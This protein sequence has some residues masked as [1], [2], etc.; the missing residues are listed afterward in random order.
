MNDKTQI[1]AVIFGCSGL[2]LTPQERAF[3]KEN[4]P[5]GL[6][7]FDRNIKDPEQLKALI[8]D[9]KKTVGREDAPILVD[10]EGGRV[11]RLWPPY[12]NGLGWNRT[13]G[14][15][16]AITPQKGIDGVKKHAEI[17]AHDLLSVGINVDCWPCLDVAIPTT[18]EIMIK[19]CFSDD[20]KIVSILGKVA[21][22]TALKNGLMPIVKHIPGYGRT[23]VDPHKGL[24]IVTDPLDT[25]EQTDFIPFKAV[26]KPVWGMTAHVIYTALDD[27]RPATLSKTVLDYVRHQIGFNGFLVCDD[28]SMGA[29][30]TYGSMADL[31]TQMIKAGCDAVLHCNGN[32]AE[33]NEIATIVPALSTESITRLNRAKEL[34]HG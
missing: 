12:W 14:D 30:S 9:F 2:S 33:M 16:Y 23:Q 17:L 8:N 20:P 4:N 5:L 27:E 1:K 24:P 22:D 13:Y 3:F 21:I 32:M 6:I 31:A 15:W 19:R 7:L 11:T 26:T 10:Q 29:L 28:I 25:L 34:I 18:H